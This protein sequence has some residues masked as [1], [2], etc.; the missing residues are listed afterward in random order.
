[1]LRATRLSIERQVMLEAKIIEV[2][3]SSEFQSGINWA[4]FN[5]SVAAGQLSSNAGAS[6]QLAP[7]GTAIGTGAAASGLL[8]N[9]E[10]RS[11]ATA[12]GAFAA[13]NPA[14]ADLGLSLQTP[15]VAPL[16]TFLAS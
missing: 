4:I 15:S 3:L 2:T 9:T 12:T 10:T 14:A 6:T 16:L 7:R 13:S 1:Y 5:R 11:V 8:A